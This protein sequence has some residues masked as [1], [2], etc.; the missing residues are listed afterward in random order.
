MRHRALGWANRAMYKMVGYDAGSLYGKN[1][2]LLYPDD[3]E[4]VRATQEL[5]RGIKETGIGAGFLEL[6]KGANIRIYKG[7]F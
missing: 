6:R 3:E 2:R 1:V 7:I 5:Y 4:Y